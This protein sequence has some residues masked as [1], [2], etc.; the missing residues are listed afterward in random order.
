L[1]SGFHKGIACV[2]AF[3]K[4]VECLVLDHGAFY[5]MCSQHQP[6]LLR[7]YED[8]FLQALEELDKPKMSRIALSESNM[9]RFID[10][11]TRHVCSNWKEIAEKERE[12]EDKKREERE[13]AGAVVG[14]VAKQDKSFSSSTQ[15]NAGA[16]IGAIKL[17]MQQ[18]HA[19]IVNVSEQVAEVLVQV[20]S[21]LATSQDTAVSVSKIGLV[22]DTLESTTMNIETNLEATF[23]VM[24]GI[25][26]TISSGV[27]VGGAFSSTGQRVFDFRSQQGGGGIRA[28][29]GARVSPGDLSA[30]EDERIRKRIEEAAKKGTKLVITSNVVTEDETWDSRRPQVGVQGVRKTGQQTTSNS[31]KWQADKVLDGTL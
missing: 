26:D 23:Q 15:S 14:V 30:L 9:R 29:G 11:T 8:E 18:M 10:D 22:A 5:D 2:I 1:L 12:V 24:Q 3:D 16:T 6:A 4:A 28:G 20:K 25:T 17:A 19:D 31:Q 21:T 27:G 13:N 7:N